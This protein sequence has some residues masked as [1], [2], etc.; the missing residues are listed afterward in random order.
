MVKKSATKFS[1][2]ASFIL[3]IFAAACAF[4]Q[5]LAPSLEQLKIAADAGDPVAQDKL[6]ERVNAAQAEELYRKAA[7][8]GYAHAQ[9]RLGNILLMRYRLF[10]GVKSEVRAATGDEAIK[11]VTLAANQGDKQGEASFSQIYLEGKLVK[12]DLIEAYKWGELSAKN[13]TLEFIVFSGASF[14]DEAILKMNADQI[15][16]AHRRVAAFVPHKPEMNEL[17]EPRWVQ[18][19]Q[20]GGISG[21]PGHRFV[22]IN[23]KTFE[24]GDKAT[25]KIDGLNVTIH[26]VEIRE[27][28]ASVS[29]EGI[30][31]TRELKMPEH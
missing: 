29:I 17:P 21:A 24:K 15:A 27:S 4:A 6:A 28:S 20:L 16:E 9:G 7:E 12:Q 2:G 3:L 19:V 14:R 23:G 1:G 22:I 18:K 13:P 25:V 30:E 31:G 10:I 8:N 11:W 26:C 5:L